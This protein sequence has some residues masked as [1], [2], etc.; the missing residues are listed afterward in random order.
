MICRCIVTSIPITKGTDHLTFRGRGCVSPVCG[1]VP[2]TMVFTVAVY[3]LNGIILIFLF[4]VGIIPNNE[5]TSFL[6][7]FLC[8]C[9]FVIR[10]AGFT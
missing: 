3:S 6:Y 8:T 2:Q 7:T 1:I 10:I 5:K 9:S 4:Y